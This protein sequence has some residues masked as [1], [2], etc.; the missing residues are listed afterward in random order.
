MTTTAVGEPR[1]YF[2]ILT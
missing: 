2:L 1:I